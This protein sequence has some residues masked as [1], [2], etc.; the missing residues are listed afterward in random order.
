[1]QI[2]KGSEFPFESAELMDY[3]L[4]KRRLKRGGLYKR[5]PEWLLHKGAT[6]N[7]KNENNDECLRWSTISALN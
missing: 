3:K 1:M 7:R 2:I 4:H 6:I 5:S